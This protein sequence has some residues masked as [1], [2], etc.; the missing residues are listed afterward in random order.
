M[1][2]EWFL[3][4]VAESF[5]C[6][7]CHNVVVNPL[8]HIDCEH[9]F[10]KSCLEPLPHAVCPCCRGRLQN[11]TKPME[12]IVKEFYEK[13]Q[14]RC[15]NPGCCEAF[16][17]TQRGD[18]ERVCGYTGHI[19][20][21]VPGCSFTGPNNE[22]DIHNDTSIQEH[23]N[24]YMK[25]L[26]EL[27]EKVNKSECEYRAYQKMV[28]IEAGIPVKNWIDERLSSSRK[29]VTL[30]FTSPPPLPSSSSSSS[31][32]DDSDAES[33]IEFRRIWREAEAARSARSSNP[34]IRLP[35]PPFTI[36]SDGN[37]SGSKRLIPSALSDRSLSTHVS[38]MTVIGHQLFCGYSDGS[39]C[40]WD[41]RTNHC[42]PSVKAHPQS[43]N[44][45][46]ISHCSES[47]RL[48]TTC[49]REGCLKVWTIDTSNDHA[50][51]L[52]LFK[53]FPM[54]SGCM[55]SMIAS[56]NGSD[57]FY[58]DMVKTTIEV[59]NVA[60]GIKTTMGNKHKRSVN[61]LE[62]S[63][64]RL[65]SGSRDNTINVWDWISLEHIATLTGHT[66]DVSSLLLHGDRLFSASMDKTIR[67][68]DTSTNTCITTIQSSSYLPMKMIMAK[69]RLHV[70]FNDQSKIGVFDINSYERLEDLSE[71]SFGTRLLASYGNRIFSGVSYRKDLKVYYL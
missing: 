37:A 41:L 61:C 40:E 54:V 26:K 27:E 57:V 13:L 59:L 9:L 25:R 43:I 52:Q 35:S 19:Q 50:N 23:K 15:E 46:A 70:G 6:S 2:P 5:L 10:C 69:N 31:S 3:D 42:Y 62:I 56:Y 53:S 1:N 45:L 63:T 68:W 29:K 36:D 16:P 38:A 18:H 8:E 4:T 66:H 11:K 32:D 21:T 7:I 49:Q 71:E 51:G 58:G 33:R 67:V 12:P 22:I 60:S 14:M 47:C 28:L 17:W 44:M 20:C 64:T 55:A 48:Y 24:L 39:I 65:Y 34:P 30:P